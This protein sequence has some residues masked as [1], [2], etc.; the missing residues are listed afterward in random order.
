MWSKFGALLLLCMM[1]PRSARGQW[2]VQRLVAADYPP[3]AQQAR[4]Q[5]KVEL[6]CDISNSGQVLTCKA[7]TGHPLLVSFAIENLKKW[8]FRRIADS[9][10]SGDQVQLDYEFVLTSGTPTR[11]RP[12]V[13]FSFEL[14]NHVR[15]ASEIPCADHIPCTPE[16]WKQFERE[17]SKK[18]KRYLP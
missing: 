14:P 6:A 9:E 17:N 2:L 11:G 10:S 13:E 4:I 8:T 5:G 18:S 12:K 7:V 15:V 3:L 16:E 1:S